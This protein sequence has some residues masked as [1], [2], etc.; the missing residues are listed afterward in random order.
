MPQNQLFSSSW[1][2]NSRNGK[3]VKIVQKFQYLHFINLRV[4]D[5]F[6]FSLFTY[7]LSV[8]ACVCICT[9]LIEYGR[10]ILQ[11]MGGHTSHCHVLG[12]F[13]SPIL[14]T[15]IIYVRC[16]KASSV[17]GTFLAPS[18]YSDL[19][20]FYSRIILSLVCLTSV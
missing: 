20:C 8:S 1:Y 6:S 12:L 17:K 10:E 4:N 3:K 13:S 7:H 19:H 2:T 15:E 16:L 9:V 11:P 14:L 5:R 18:H